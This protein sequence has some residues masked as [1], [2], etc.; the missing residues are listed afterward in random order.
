MYGK[1][2]TKG[3]EDKHTTTRIYNSDYSDESPDII[4][5]KKHRS[6]CDECI[7]D[8]YDN[9]CRL[10]YRSVNIKRFNRSGDCPECND[11][12][13]DEVFF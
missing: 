3:C 10:S 1:N 11:Y 9:Y 7:A 6:D 8:E 5:I 13:D 2:V 12:M 4:Y